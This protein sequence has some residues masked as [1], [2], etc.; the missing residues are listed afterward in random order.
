MEIHS[1]FVDTPST[2]T[3]KRSTKLSYAGLINPAQFQLINLTIIFIYSQAIILLMPKEDTLHDEFTRLDKKIVKWMRK[4]GH[5]WLRFSLGI[6]FFW[7]GI[8]KPLGLSPAS[9]LVASTVYWFN[10]TF[11]VPILGWW[12]VIIGLCL[13]YKPLL[14]IG[15]FLMAVQMAGT[16]LP[17]ILLP[18][19]VYGNTIFEL[20]LEGQYIV[21][22]IVLITAGLVVGSH[23]RD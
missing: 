10:P 13:M 1:F 3:A 17:M 22:N 6:I 11:F 16:F 2:S 4:N 18:E 15:L 23:A 14:R 8:L 7:F 12:E 9:E 19:V 5:T 20:T 21:K